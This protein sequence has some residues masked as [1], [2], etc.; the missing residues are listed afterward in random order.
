MSVKKVCIPHLGDVRCGNRCKKASMKGTVKMQSLFTFILQ[1]TGNR[2]Y[3]S[4][5]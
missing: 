3:I 1:K 2:L 5:L 4:F